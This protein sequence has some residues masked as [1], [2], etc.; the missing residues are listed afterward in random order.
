MFAH[1]VHMFPY[2]STPSVPFD[3]DEDLLSTNVSI[4]LYISV[5][6]SLSITVF[7]PSFHPL[8]ILSVTFLWFIESRHLAIMYCKRYK[9]RAPSAENLSSHLPYDHIF[10]YLSRYRKQDDLQP[11]I[12]TPTI[13]FLCFGVL[14]NARDTR[15]ASS[16]TDVSSRHQENIKEMYVGGIDTVAIVRRKS[17]RIFEGCGAR[18]TGVPW[19]YRLE[20]RWEE[21]VNFAYDELVM[22]E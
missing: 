15:I 16:V 13:M 8:K 20:H 10:E 22:I 17:N 21:T 3:K 9:H 18:E 11:S 5:Y 19:M 7:I 4:L 12:R 6:L 1:H 2:F 14:S